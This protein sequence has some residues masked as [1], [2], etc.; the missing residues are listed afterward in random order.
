V[1][2]DRAAAPTVDAFALVGAVPAVAGGLMVL[3]A[4]ALLGLHFGDR[5]HQALA[6]FL[7]LRGGL[8]IGAGLG[9]FAEWSD[10]AGR[11]SAYFLLALPFAA[12]YFAL[13]YV[14]RYGHGRPAAFLPWALLA[15]AL[16][17]ELAYVARH[18][19][20]PPTFLVD[21]LGV[22]AD[23]SSPFVLGAAGAQLAYALLS[24]LLL[25]EARGIT[26]APRRRALHAA[27][28]GFALNPLFLGSLFGGSLLFALFDRAYLPP[29]PYVRAVATL[30]LLAVPLLWIGWHRGLRRHPRQRRRVHGLFQLTAITALVPLALT[31]T[32]P[33]AALTLVLFEAVWTLAMPLLLAYAL[34]RHHFLDL[35]VRLH[36]T[37]SRG[38]TGALFVAIFFAISETAQTL[39]QDRTGS[40][41]I[42]IGGTALLLF[43]FHPLTRATDRLA[44]RALPDARPVG[45]HP[46]D[47][48]IEL[49]REQV[50]IA[51]SDGTITRKDRLMLEAAR[52]KLRLSAEDALRLEREA[53][54]RP[55]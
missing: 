10:Y 47:V 50:R 8:N 32:W 12:V 23:A 25:R 54:A 38:T 11:V 18:D 13:V 31:P 26:S 40:T 37:L 3:L 34:L 4:L 6:L 44:T 33:Q 42:A 36:W 52:T 29:N 35:D 16:A 17:L 15:G 20:W 49:Y 5:L 41:S 14:R 27:S 7:L 19:L 45:D 9:R 55:M 30:T 53:A 24:L 2:R 39:L 51:W 46:R 43:A 28:L 48:R 22:P 21:P 1:L